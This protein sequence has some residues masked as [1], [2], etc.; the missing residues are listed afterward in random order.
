[1]KKASFKKQRVK[2]DDDLLPEYDFTQMKGGV[3]GKYY[4]GYREGHSVTIHKT[5]GTTVVQNFKVE[6][7]VVKLDRDVRE[8]FPDAESVNNAL[9][10]LIAL[11]PRKQRKAK[12]KARAT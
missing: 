3:R 8:F 11:L 6:D 10:G 1:M 7:G 12:T 2:D 4:Q 9:R 5:D